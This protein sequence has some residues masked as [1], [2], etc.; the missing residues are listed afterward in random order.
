VQRSGLYFI[1]PDF[2]LNQLSTS[3][4]PVTSVTGGEDGMQESRGPPPRDR[5]QDPLP[6]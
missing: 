5:L 6:Y 2:A 1:M 4:L 3:S